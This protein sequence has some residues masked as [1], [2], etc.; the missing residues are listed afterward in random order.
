MGQ[1]EF[2][3]EKFGFKKAKRSLGNILLTVLLYIAVSV[4]LAVVYYIIFSFVISTD[5]ERRLKRENRM[6]EKIYPQMIEREKL[7]SEVITGL[8]LKDDGIYNDIFHSPAPAIDPVNTVDFL[9][10]VDSVKDKDLVD[11]TA[12]K[13]QGIDEVASRVESNF[14]D[15]IA[16]FSSKYE[17]IP[18]M[19]TPVRNLSYAQFGASVGNKV[20]PFYKV[21][22]YHSG[23]DL[24]APQGDPVYATADGYVSN[25]I[26]SRKGQGN[27]VEITHPGGYV[28]RYCHLAGEIEV[29]RG[30]NVKKG[31]V[32]GYIGISGQSFAPHLHYEVLKDTVALDPI[33]YMFASVTPDEYANMLFMSS[34]TGQSLD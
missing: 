17:V 34:R 16:T 4:S 22:V 15:I 8:Q 7:I 3:K 11:Y 6:Y 25:V 2:D 28:T 24:I 9:S 21:E 19:N 14:K 20:N 10:A 1:Y 13:I 18:P 32:L 30:Q 5:F 29:S 31:K 26:T 33:N 12:M 27:V 23:L